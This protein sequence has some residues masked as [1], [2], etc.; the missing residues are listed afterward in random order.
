M[1]IILLDFFPV[2]IALS[3]VLEG[4]NLYLLCCLQ[5]KYMITTIMKMG[6]R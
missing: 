3:Y 4:E 5:R 2:N 6:S 1:Y